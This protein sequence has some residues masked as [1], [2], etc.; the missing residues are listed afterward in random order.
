MILG[1]A[2]LVATNLDP[3]ARQRLRGAIITPDPAIVAW[4]ARST[5]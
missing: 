3:L 5:D 2:K 4:Q 1:G